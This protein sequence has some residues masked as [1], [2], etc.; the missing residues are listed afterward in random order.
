MLMLTLIPM[1]SNTFTRIPFIVARRVKP[2]CQPQRELHPKS[3]IRHDH[4]VSLSASLPCGAG[5]IGSPYL[6]SN[7]VVTSF[8]I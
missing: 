6:V 8:G 1:L 7:S 4:L 5:I 2:S 3:S